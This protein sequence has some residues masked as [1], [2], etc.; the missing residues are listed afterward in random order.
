[1]GLE[2]K[3]GGRQYGQR[4]LRSIDHLLHC[5]QP[6]HKAIRPLGLLGIPPY[7]RQPSRACAADMI[8]RTSCPPI[9]LHPKIPGRCG[10]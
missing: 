9:I 10:S 7:I 3:C 4:H 8:I 2:Q 6:E 1:M 5:S